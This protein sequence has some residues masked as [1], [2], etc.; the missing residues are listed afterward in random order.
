M[1]PP[2]HVQFDWAAVAAHVARKQAE[3][4]ARTDAEGIECSLSAFRRWGV[5][6][7][8]E[9]NRAVAAAR[10]RGPN[11]HAANEG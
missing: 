6:P 4:A 2:R 7:P 11:N 5:N 8:A 1:R 10:R 9:F 3:D